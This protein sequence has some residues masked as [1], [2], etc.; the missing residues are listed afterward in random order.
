MLYLEL[1]FFKLTYGSL[2][3]PTWNLGLLLGLC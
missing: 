2:F 1:C 3:S